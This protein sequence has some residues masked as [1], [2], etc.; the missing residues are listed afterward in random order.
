M[1]KY[2]LFYNFDQWATMMK[3]L[4]DAAPPRDCVAGSNIATTVELDGIAEHLEPGEWSDRR[5]GFMGPLGESD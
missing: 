1:T 2:N 5:R 3:T 4:K